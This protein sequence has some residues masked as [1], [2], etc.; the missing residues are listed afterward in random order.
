MTWIPGLAYE[1][2]EHLMG[3]IMNEND[4]KWSEAGEAQR[5]AQAHIAQQQMGQ[6][7]TMAHSDRLSQVAAQAAQVAGCDKRMYAEDIK[8]WSEAKIADWE[9]Q[10][11]VPPLEVQ[12]ARHIV[13][14]NAAIERVVTENVTLT[15]QIDKSCGCPC[16]ATRFFPAQEK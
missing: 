5:Q 12:L 2:L 11:R 4:K 1:A 8:K 13:E 10:Q 6:Q 15:A 3:D 14:L 7:G 16:K 9:R